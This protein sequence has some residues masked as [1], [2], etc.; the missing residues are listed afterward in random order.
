MTLAILISTY[1]IKYLIIA[2]H[3]TFNEVLLEHYQGLDSNSR[4]PKAR[5]DWLTIARN[6]GCP[7]FDSLSSQ[8]K[9]FSLPIS[10]A[11]F[12]MKASHFAHA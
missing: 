6:Q 10:I 11:P 9:D 1:Y 7:G 2:L 5:Y 4:P 12:M 3:Y 8:T